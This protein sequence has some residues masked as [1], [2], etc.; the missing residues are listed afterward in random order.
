MKSA[1]PLPYLFIQQVAE[2]PLAAVRRKLIV[3]P[4]LFGM[5]ILCLGCI[6]NKSLFYA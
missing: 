2:P 3:T 6:Y 5:A 4:H 1:G